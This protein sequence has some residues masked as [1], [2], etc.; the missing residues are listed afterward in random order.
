M[1]YEQR[2]Q[3]AVNEFNDANAKLYRR[4][5]TSKYAP[6]ELEERKAEIAKAFREKMDAIDAELI[7]EEEKR[8]EA[9]DRAMS[10]GPLDAL[11]NAELERANALRSFIKEDT[12]TASIEE[13]AGMVRAAKG[14]KVRAFLLARYAEPRY[15]KELEE[16]GDHLTVRENVA[17][18]RL[19]EALSG[20]KETLT[21]PDQEKARA[22]AENA[23]VE[24]SRLRGRLG[25]EKT[26]SDA[27]EDDR[28]VDVRE[29]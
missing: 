11:S 12:E 4:D 2:I 17:F 28:V 19:S 18:R 9:L 6:A 15:R 14:D 13:L 7:E 26:V 20:L 27:Y 24:V 10:A 25:H 5:G 3:A 22:D 16:R 8:K 21:T 29:L 1:N 23:V